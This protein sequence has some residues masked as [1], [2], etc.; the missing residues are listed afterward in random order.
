MIFIKEKNTQTK[1]LCFCLIL[2]ESASVDS[3]QCVSCTKRQFKEAYWLCSIIRYPTNIWS[4][5][6]TP[7][8]LQTALKTTRRPLALKKYKICGKKTMIHAEFL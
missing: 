7:Q 5:L 6:T 1:A 2:K 4:S 8:R 3:G